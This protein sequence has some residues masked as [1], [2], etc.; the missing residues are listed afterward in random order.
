MPP[1]DARLI[2]LVLFPYAP[3]SR[4]TG[5]GVPLPLDKYQAPYFL[6]LDIEVI[7]LGE[8]SWVIDGVTVEVKRQVFD[9]EVSLVE[10][11]YNLADVLNPACNERK[12]GL[13]AKLLAAIRAEA[14]YEGPFLEEYSIVCLAD[15]AE[16][17]DEFVQANRLTLAG[18]LRN[19]PRA[20]N[21][22]ETD[23][24]LASRARYTDR[25]LVV[26]D[27]EGAL[28]I[29]PS[30]DFRSDVELL[31]IG[32]YELL[33]YRLLDRAIERNLQV[34]RDELESKRRLNFFSSV[35]R[36]ALE[37]RLALLLDFEKTEQLLLL[38]G[39]W[40][41]AQLY[42]LIVDEF[43][44]DDWKVTVKSKIEQLESITDIIHEN[45][46]IGWRQTLDIVQLVGWLV[47]LAGYFILFY[48]ELGRAIK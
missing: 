43:Y 27:W 9:E 38:I 14:A 36:E 4:V 37:Q 31:K 29:D 35:V 8:S 48:L 13:Q 5:S 15:V 21:E 30:Q 7:N 3:S 34:V 18:L 28:L 24:I 1:L 6:D 11:R 20:V 23:Q 17:P 45:F 22:A 2:Y 46:T 42:R 41:S 12:Q 33:R 19:V 10:C 47:L 39:D 16:A 44:I 40:Y 32:N 25:D 26:V